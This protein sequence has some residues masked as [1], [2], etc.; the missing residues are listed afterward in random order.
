MYVLHIPRG[1]L[2]KPWIKGRIFAAGE[3]RFLR[4]VRG[5]K[6]A[7]GIFGLSISARLAQ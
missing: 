4:G 3:G 6:K 1:H 5:A 2:Y 7:A